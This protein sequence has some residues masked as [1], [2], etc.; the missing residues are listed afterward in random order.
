MNAP[1]YGKHQI[2]DSTF[3]A[4]HAEAVKLCAACPVIATCRRR[5]QESLEASRDPS[6][7]PGGTWAGEL[8]IKGRIVTSAR[9]L[10]AEEIAYS[11]EDARRAHAAWWR[12]ERD[13]WT[14]A[15]ER[16]YQRR[17]CRRQRVSRKGAA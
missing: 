3:L 16:V 2:F 5:L 9:R 10:A 6:A 13:G 7:Q 17:A 1:C 15:G 4:D 14:E 12:G 8:V 11:D